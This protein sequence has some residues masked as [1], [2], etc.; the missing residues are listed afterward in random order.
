M[1]LAVDGKEIF[2]GNAPAEETIE[3][4]TQDWKNQ[5]NNQP[6][7]GSGNRPPAVED[8]VKGQKSIGQK[9]NME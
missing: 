6:G 8:D 4:K 2:L 9:Q 7:P 1:M 3:D 5:Q